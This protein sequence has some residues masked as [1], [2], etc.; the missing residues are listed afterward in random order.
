MS[1]FLLFQNRLNAVLTW[2][3]RTTLLT[4]LIS[5]KSRVVSIT[6]VVGS[7]SSSVLLVYQE[8][9]PPAEPRDQLMSH[10][11]VWLPPQTLQTS[12]YSA[13]QWLSRQMIHVIAA[14]SLRFPMTQIFQTMTSS[15]TRPLSVLSTL[16]VT[17]LRL[18]RNVRLTYKLIHDIAS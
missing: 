6:S 18:I 15:G 4:C 14:R 13:V 3:Y 9:I 7:R 11:D 16:P 17:A 12:L 5:S 1:V 8:V 2:V 10:T